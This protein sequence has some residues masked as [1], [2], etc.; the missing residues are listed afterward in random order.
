[1][2]LPLV[3]FSLLIISYSISFAAPGDLIWSRHYGGTNNHEWGQSVQQTSDGGYIIGGYAQFPR[4]TWE[5]L[6]LI[7]TDSNG[8]TIWTRTYGGSNDDRAYSVKQTSDGGYILTGRTVSFGI[9]GDIY[10]VKTDSGGDTLWTRIYGGNSQDVGFSIQQTNDGGYIIG[11][12]TLSFGAGNGDFYII[13]INSFGDTLWTRT[14]GGS[15]ADWAYSVQQTSDGGYI[16]GG[17][18]WSYGA[19]SNDF[20]LIITDSLGD[21]LWAHT[22]GGSDNEILESVKQTDDGGYILAG[23][24]QSYGVGRDDVYIVKTDSIGDTLWTRTYGGYYSE[25]GYSVTRTWDGSYAVTGYTSSFVSGTSDCFVVRF[26]SLGNLLWS[27]NYGGRYGDAGNSI[28][29]TDDSCLIIAGYTYI[30]A[31]SNIWSDVYLL[32]IDDSEF[33]PPTV[34]IDMMPD[35]PPIDVYPGDSFTYTGSIRNNTNTYLTGDVWIMLDV[36]GYGIYG[37]LERYNN[38][39]LQP[40]Q[41]ISIEDIEQHVP[42]YAPSGLY[43]Y[44]AYCGLYPDHV[45]D[46]SF[47]QFR[48]LSVAV[49]VAD[50]WRLS[51]WFPSHDDKL[52]PIPNDYV[53]Y[54]NYPNPFNTGTRFEFSLPN[55]GNA[56]LD[57]YNLIGQKVETL[58]DGWT[59]AGHHNIRWDASGFA[60]G[61]YFY[62]LTAGETAI[63]RRMTLLK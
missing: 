32:K 13:K 20:Y 12:M 63:T 44:I 48:V 50:E 49:G 17:E 53:L 57:V 62:K 58:I 6:Y 28:I 11:G 8:D 56:R 10:V 26:D 15:E 25:Y 47:F 1:M 38:I 31:G 43:E 7:K 55:A 5:D 46:T 2:R 42:R 41:F 60:S 59:E 61:I 18:T 19:G 4:I 39:P 24:T 33:I 29:A 3:L 22:Y 52:S 23:R 35:D 36:P 51:G 21:S 37:P 16:I 40:Y 45:I 9:G 14:Y 27:R 30:Q 34:S 54:N